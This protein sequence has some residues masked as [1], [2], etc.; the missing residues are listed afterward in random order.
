MTND[1][2]LFNQM[3]ESLMDHITPA[4]FRMLW[5][6]YDTAVNKGLNYSLAI[7]A[8]KKNF[9]GS[10][11]LTTRVA[12]AVGVHLEGHDEYWK[13]I[14]ALVGIPIFESLFEYIRTKDKNAASGRAKRHNPKKKIKR[15]EKMRESII[16]EMKLEPEAKK[17][18]KTYESGLALERKS[19]K[20][21]F[22]NV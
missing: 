11:S 5:H 12:L 17:S 1:E 9:S 20:K 7:F 18:E 19:A 22:W 13:K 10:M 14:L 4:K 15:S 2:A 21:L 6:D 3:I 16:T 8:P